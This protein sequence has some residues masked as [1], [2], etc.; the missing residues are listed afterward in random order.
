MTDQ[1]EYFRCAS[2][3]LT[4]SNRADVSVFHGPHYRWRSRDV[5]LPANHNRRESRNSLNLCA[6]EC[7]EVVVCNTHI[8]IVTTCSASL[9]LCCWTHQKSVLLLEFSS[10]LLATAAATGPINNRTLSDTAGG[11]GRTLRNHGCLFLCRNASCMS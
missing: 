3:C 11:Y 4:S 7:L 5:L 6:C 1:L 9:M 10:R 8:E 2:N